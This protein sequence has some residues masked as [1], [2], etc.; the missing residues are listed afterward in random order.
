LLG[1]KKGGSKSKSLTMALRKATL[2]L[3]LLYSTTAVV[4]DEVELYDEHFTKLGCTAV[5]VARGATTDGSLITTHNAD[6]LNCDF[7]IAKT[8]AM[9]HAKGSTKTILKYKVR[10][11]TN[12]ICIFNC[13]C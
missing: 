3:S 8:P 2:A 4:Y 12:N 13:F 5:I 9:T 10:Y 7:R 6:C 1:A 11:I